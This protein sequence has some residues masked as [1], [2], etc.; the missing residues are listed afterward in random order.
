[1]KREIKC[2]T[3][4]GDARRIGTIW[5]ATHEDTDR[6]S[7]TAELVEFICDNPCNTQS[8]WL[9]KAEVCEHEP[10]GHTVHYSGERMLC[11]VTC[12]KCGRSGSFV[13]TSDDIDW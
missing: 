7:N 8:F 3:C 11:D 13:V 10:E 5:K 9:P 12:R 6:S 2:P 4:G 1:M